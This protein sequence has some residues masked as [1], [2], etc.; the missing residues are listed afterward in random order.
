[1]RRGSEIVDRSRLGRRRNAVV[2]V[3]LVAVVLLAGQLPLQ[4]TERAQAVSSGQFIEVESGHAWGQQWGGPV[5][6]TWVWEYNTE[7][8][9]NNV[10]NRGWL[11]QFD[12]SGVEI[13]RVR[14][15]NKAPVDMTYGA[16]GTSY[17]LLNDRSSNVVSLLVVPVF[18]SETEHVL[19]TGDYTTIGERA[20]AMG[21][22]GFLYARLY[23]PGYRTLKI[24]L[25]SI[26]V[27]S[28]VPG[29]GR[30]MAA[31][32]PGVV[33]YDAGAAQLLPYGSTEFGPSYVPPG[34]GG[35][36]GSQLSIAED[37][38]LYQL[39]APYD[40]SDGSYSCRLASVSRAR[41]GDGGWRKPISGLVDLQEGEKCHAHDVSAMPGSGGVVIE[42]LRHIGSDDAVGPAVQ[43]LWLDATGT[44]V[45][46]RTYKPDVS[47]VTYNGLQPRG[48]DLLVDAAGS[49]FL[50]VTVPSHECTDM[51][52]RVCSSLHLLRFDSAHNLTLNHAILPT[53]SGDEASVELFDSAFVQAQ[54]LQLTDGGILVPVTRGSFYCGDSCSSYADHTQ[55]FVLP[56]GAPRT[57]GERTYVALGDSYSSGEGNAPFLKGTD[58]PGANTCHRSSRAYAWQL[59]KAEEPALTGSAFVFKPCSGAQTADW[60]NENGT[61][62]NCEVG[63]DRSPNQ[64]EWPQLR[65]LESTN[66]ALLTLT[67]GG[68]DICFPDIAAQCISGRVLHRREGADP[69]CAS[70]MQPGGKTLDATV[71]ERIERL[72]LSLRDLYGQI[73]TRASYVTPNT[74]VLGYPRQT[75]HKNDI[76]GR[77]RRPIRQEDGTTAR[78][79]FEISVANMT[80]IHDIVHLLNTTIREE[81]TRAGFTYVDVENAFRHH[82][83]C[84][85]DPWIH[86][87]VLKNDYIRRGAAGEETTSSWSLHPK[88]RGHEEMKD[89]VS[90]AIHAET[91]QIDTILHPG[92]STFDTVA[93]APSTASYTFSSSWP[94]SEVVMRVTSPSGR[95]I[96]RGTDADDV[97][98][99]HGET[100][101]TYTVQNPEPGQWKVELYGANVRSEGERTTMTGTAIPVSDL[102][103]IA[104]IDASRDRGVGSIAVAFDGAHSSSRTEPITSWEW[105]FGDGATATGPTVSHTYSTSGDHKATL[106]VR[107]ADGLFSSTSL[108]IKVSAT[109]SAPR[110][111][112]VYAESLVDGTYRFDASNSEDVDGDIVTYAWDFQGDGV[113]DQSGPAPEAVHAYGTGETVSP[114]LTITDDLGAT[115]T[116]VGTELTS[117]TSIQ[118]FVSD[119]TTGEPLANVCARLHDAGGL[120]IGDQTCSDQNGYYEF[121][122]APEGAFK[123]HFTDQTGDHQARWSG[124][125]ADVADADVVE[126]VKGDRVDLSVS[127]RD[128][129]E[130][131]TASNTGA[132]ETIGPPSSSN[133]VVTRVEDQGG[134]LVE[135]DELVA[136]GSVPS[137]WT[138]LATIDVHVTGGSGGTKVF[139][140]KLDKSLLPP[141]ESSET[142]SLHRD[143]VPLAPC[144]T[145]GALG[146][147]PCVKMSATDGGGAIT[148]TAM[149][150][151]TST[152]TI[153]APTPGSIQASCPSGLVPPSGF[154]DT[155]GNNHA[156]AIDCLK[157]WH[158]TNGTTSTS[159]SPSS[160][161]TRA[162]MASFLVR[163]IEGSGVVLDPGSDAFTDDDGNTHEANINKLA[164]AG[165]TSGR[166]PGAY[167]PGG[168]VTRA[169]MATFLAR[170]YEKVAA[171]T[172]SL[173]GIV[174][175]FSDDN[176][177]THEV[178]INK[179]ALLGITQG[180]TPTTYDPASNLTRAQMA[181]L[182]AR[183]LS[184]LVAEGAAPAFNPA[185]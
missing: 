10:G 108:A 149:S 120:P 98:H 106:T 25:P 66:V 127:L 78:G 138:P 4:F 183:T 40:S 36:E 173:E 27:E 177:L 110:A 169:Q 61:A 94:G 43:L 13:R 91:Y 33:G 8:L 99:S 179:V 54:E 117:K 64:G 126:V 158:I 144:V 80:W 118:G 132:A 155:E 89:A 81:A 125:V 6:S 76:D 141:G 95:V 46:E 47:R 12:L 65:H 133:R 109:N 181:S 92:E 75:P 7:P 16:D 3:L 67:D 2:V 84:S 18:G 17:A 105:N 85:D 182:L 49:A 184:R 68:N 51:P 122:P 34:A 166:S 63:A 163:L 147:D 1:M 9:D 154:V 129:T 62:S 164:A 156:A 70:S 130:R 29:G 57:A 19:R 21:D 104:V 115:G 178:N 152:W 157:A 176:G 37:A 101:E 112:L 165:I 56:T 162:Q 171:R 100:A 83:V 24:E 170:T 93:V 143:G 168:L 45:A 59:W 22:D 128:W 151:S 31:A 39:H 41:P 42:L 73:K 121:D 58:N 52:G 167:D 159:Y 35:G 90:R 87:I 119:E 44:L 134:G 175:R 174:D 124:D 107:T 48:S 74:Y 20:L 116:S 172:V 69:N 5:S 26:V 140:F 32:R 148:V 160:T 79:S 180:K 28:E 97:V 30:D 103:P 11:R 71:R 55:T 146:P 102:A 15:E 60:S 145:D 135:I 131:D 114:L 153:A 14:L 53:G 86:G 142:L 139:I 150:S 50:A 136:L 72:R 23:G 82:D 123:V 161:V 88:A 113:V 38:S 77:C 137:G 96:D 111:D 185:T